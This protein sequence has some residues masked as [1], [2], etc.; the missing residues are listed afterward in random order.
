[1]VSPESVLAG[2]DDDQRRVTEAV[3]GPVCVLA[4]AGTGKTRAIT[5]RIAYAALSG[6]VHPSQILAVTFTT[7]AAS[8]MRG[9]IRSLGVMGT[10]ART[11]H[12][13]ALR[14]LTYFWPRVVGGPVPGVVESKI[15]LLAD[16][17]RETGGSG[18]ARPE[19][20]DLASEIEW[21]KVTQVRPDGYVEAARQAGRQ[22][23]IEPMSLAQMFAAYEEV[24]R[25]RNLL[26]FESILELTAA[27][28][29]ENDGV[30]SEVR[31][32]YR[33]FVVDEYQD[34]NPLQKLLL[35]CWLGEREEIC[36]VGDPAQTIYSFAG[37]SP[38]YLL[39]FSREHPT[40]T[41]IRMGRDYRSTPQVVTL[42]NALMAARPGRHE[43]T[44][45]AQRPC[46]PQ[47]TFNEFD[48]EVVEAAEVVREVK[49]L[50]ASG[51]AAREI[52]VL[53]RINAQS[54]R[55]EHAFAES[56]IACVVRGSVPF[57]ERPEIRQAIVLLRG[58]ARSGGDADATGDLVT[59]IRHVLASAGL[60]PEPPSGGGSSRERW[61]AL[62]ALVRLAEE[63][64][65]TG[66]ADLSAFV[67]ELE[68]RASAEHPPPIEGVTLASLHAAKGLEWD[69]VFLVGLVE[70]ALPIVYAVTPEQIEEERRLLYVGITRARTRLW[71]SWARSRAPGG[72]RGRGPSR[73]LEA[74]PGYP[75]SSST[76]RGT[77]RSGEV[78]HE[79]GI[80]GSARS[81]RGRGRTGPVPCRVCRR[82]LTDPVE[83]KLGR[84]AGC[85][86][87]VD[88]KLLRR[89]REW[90]LETSRSH[91]VP[92]FV[93]FTDVTLTAIAERRPTTPEELLEIPGIGRAKLDRYGEELLE[94]CEG[95]R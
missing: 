12:A 32:R 4:G 11:F 37:A 73:F 25:D 14:Q 71:F 44:L 38:S 43:V 72:S 95:E 7:K 77:R 20:R 82:P 84:C 33:Y 55:F 23:P 47:A 86:S 13:A 46:G 51:V 45:V 78:T 29:A 30:A 70:G 66:V 16:A 27:L 10:Q 69:A 35:D 61:E 41:V 3:R 8:E 80:A 57:F 65:E 9:R 60:S 49:Q 50:I 58:A 34:V 64:A 48:D 79:V 6:V 26:D 62:S 59:S 24:R 76:A 40:A 21:A 93:V 68:R 63:V 39:D 52:A 42:A 56:G 94:L 28:L 92:A 74:L 36:V 15:G 22:P 83:R 89:L 18:L 67:D 85:P 17:A 88:E 19:L 5:H 81:A 54:E 75:A 90:R 53:F 31:D 87:D 2:L 91:R 1:M